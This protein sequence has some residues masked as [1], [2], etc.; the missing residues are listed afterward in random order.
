M[1]SDDEVER[2]S[3]QLVLRDWGGPGQQRLKRARVLIVGAGGLGGPAA[4]ALAGAGAGTLGLVDFDAVALSNLHRQ[5]QFDTADV[6]APKIEAAAHRLRGLNP[7]TAVEL[8]PV[9][10]GSDNARDLVR[11][12]DLVLDGTDDFTARAQVNAACMA[13]GR[14]LVSGAVARWSGQVGVFTGRPCWRCLVPA[15]PPDA[16]TCAAVGVAGPLTALIGGLM[17]LEAVKLLTGAGEP[18]IGRLLLHNGL[19]GQARTVRVAADPECPACSRSRRHSP[20]SEAREG[21]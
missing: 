11:A 7:H 13:E 5:V 8:H 3:R 19:T 1:F 6:G 9:R 4:L 16:E 10:L 21:A 12:Y 18:L 15:P 17:A 14:S 2:Y 20:E